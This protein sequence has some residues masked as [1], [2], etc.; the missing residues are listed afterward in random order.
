[1]KRSKHK[2]KGPVANQL[3]GA[4]KPNVLKS[5]ETGK[6]AKPNLLWTADAA[7]GGRE[8]DDD[9]E[10]DEILDED[11]EVEEEIDDRTPAQRRADL[12]AELEREAEEFGLTGFNPVGLYG[13]N[14]KAVA[15][16]LDSLQD[17]DDETA[18]AI[19]DAYEAVP[20][21]ERKVARSVVRRRHRGGKLYAELETAEGA[22]SD[23]LA[24]L[25]FEDGDPLYDL[26]AEAA[27]DAVD[28]LV[29]EDDLDDADFATL[30]DPWS[31][32]MGTED[33]GEAD[34]GEE[35]HEEEGKKDTEHETPEAVKGFL[36][37]LDAREADEET[38]E[39]GPNTELVV[40]FLDTLG[41]LEAAK[42]VDLIAAWREQPKEELRVAHRALQDL[43]DED[44]TW[45]EQLRLA[46]EEIFAWMDGR[47]TNYLD[48][49]VVGKETA[50]ARES[51][52]PVVA[53][54]VAALVM[55]DILE[56][57]DAETL[58]AP[59]AE[60]VGE[61]ALPTFEDEDADEDDEDDEDNDK[62]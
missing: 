29:L 52:G 53:D 31:E 46:Q 35:D 24:S 49:P 4:A 40:Q 45:R 59:W 11:E 55:A 28:A 15:A 50:A 44:E 43:A 3:K 30:Y 14:G 47:A 57:E 36:E 48:L 17:I 60:I 23:W 1:L 25:G 41:A 27:T 38:G 21:A 8:P 12:Q 61:P 39:F 22:V 54:T 56:A 10:P 33:E 20:E 18:E 7:T 62:S 51:A 42:I 5:A 2:A 26:V 6:G 58:Y 32:V 16:L 13:P 34:E 9:F 19:A 37:K